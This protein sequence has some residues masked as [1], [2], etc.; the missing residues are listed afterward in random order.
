MPVLNDGTAYPSVSCSREREFR[1]VPARRRLHFE[2]RHRLPKLRRAP[3]PPSSEMMT[4]EL[5]YSY[6]PVSKIP[7]TSNY[8]VS[9]VGIPVTGSMLDWID[10][11]QLIE[12]TPGVTFSRSASLLPSTAPRC[13]PSSVANEKSPAVAR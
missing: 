12:S 9:G 3:A 5:S 6:I 2:P 8:R 4:Y 13:C 11:E 10:R 7:V 1:R